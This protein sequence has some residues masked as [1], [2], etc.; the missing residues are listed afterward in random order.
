[1]VQENRVGEDD[2]LKQ[3]KQIKAKQ[4]SFQVLASFLILVGYEMD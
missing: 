2:D 3:K 4:F 1:M